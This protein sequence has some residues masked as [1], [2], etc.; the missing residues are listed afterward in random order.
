MLPGP[1]TITVAPDPATVDIGGSVRLTA[2]AHFDD[3]TPDDDWTHVVTWYS[4]DHDVATVN[5]GSYWGGLTYGLGVGSTDIG[6]YYSRSV[7]LDYGDLP[8]PGDPPSDDYSVGFT[9][10]TAEVAPPPPPDPDGRFLVAFDAPALEP[11]PDWTRLDD[12]PNLVTSYTIDRGRQNELDRVDAGRATVTIIDTDGILDPTNPDGPYYGKI[13][14]RRQA[15]LGRR[16]PVTGDWQIRFRGYIE[17]LVY[18][19]DPSQ[20]LNRL[21]ITLLDLFDV[22]ARAE[23]QPGTCGSP[24]SFTEVGPEEIYYEI[25]TTSN[26]IDHIL[27]DFGVPTPFQSVLV[28]DSSVWR[29]IYSAGES[30]LSALQEAAD[31]E[32]PGTNVYCDRRGRFCFH[33]RN[34]KFH[35]D[36]TAAAAGGLWDFQQWKAGDGAAVTASPSDTSQLRAF[37]FSREH[38]KIINSAVVTTVPERDPDSDDPDHVNRAHITDTASINEFG[39]CSWSAENLLTSD[40]LDGTQVNRIANYFVSNYAQPKDRIQAIEFRSLRPDDTR[41]AANWQ[42]LTQVDIGDAIEVTVGLPG[43]GGFTSAGYFIEGIHEQARPLVPDYDD[44]TVSLDLSPRAYYD[45]DPWA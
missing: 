32:L 45:T 3:G 20:K 1:T 11:Y 43:G 35:P 28:T 25:E 12:I 27:A 34:A 2:T 44:V 6:A 24:V 42:L 5:S 29:V 15:M 14:P 19:A 17:D 9:S 13:K 40:D 8:L 26:R 23:M 22:L 10:L 16:D 39:V 36:D 41:A 33:G 21:T 37:G 30:A 18:E 4:L 7:P 38:S 31:A